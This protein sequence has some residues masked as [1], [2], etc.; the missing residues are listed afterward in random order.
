MICYT[1]IYGS[2]DRLW[3]H[4]EHPGVEK[5]L[6]YTDNPNLQT[7]GWESIVEPRPYA[8]PRLSAKWRK[9]HPPEAERSL[10]VDGSVHVDNSIYIDVVSE[11]LETADMCFVPHPDR[12]NIRDE[13]RASIIQQ[14]HKY[15]QFDLDA[16]VKLYEDRIGTQKGLWAS[17][18]FGRNHTPAVLQMGAAWFVHNELLSIQDQLSLPVLLDDYGITVAPIPGGLARNPLFRWRGHIR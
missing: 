8:N 2:Y 14:P 13:A 16:Q 4:V 10:W 18:T 5:W 17:T 3:P 6:C 12:D 9:A 11:L 1:S 7:P 15:G